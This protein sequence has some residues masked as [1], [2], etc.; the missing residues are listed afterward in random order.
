M[1]CRIKP[2]VSSP[3]I[4]ICRMDEQNRYC[5]GCFRSLEEIKRWS[6]MSEDERLAV[7]AQVESRTGV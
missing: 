4:N 6:T 3:C 5:V 1:A 2:E 7:M